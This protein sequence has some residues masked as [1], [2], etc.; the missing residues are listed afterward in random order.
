MSKAKTKDDIALDGRPPRKIHF[1]S[2][3][4]TLSR[5]AL[6]FGFS[7]LIP[8]RFPFLSQTI[9]EARKITIAYKRNEKPSLEIAN[10][11]MLAT[12]SL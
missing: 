8:Q 7:S 3:L 4:S 6:P 10:A 2:L 9:P 12:D 1:S 11:S 5:D